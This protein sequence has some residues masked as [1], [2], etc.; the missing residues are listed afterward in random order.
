MK[1]FFLIAA[2]AV[3]T[4]TA[5]AQR[6][7][8]SSSS[9]F[10]TEKATQP[11]TFGA[12]AGVN[13][14]SLGGDT[15]ELDGR[16]AFNVGVSVD[17]PILESFYVQSGLYYTQKGAKREES[18]YDEYEKTT[19]SPSYLEIP[20]LASYRYNFSENSQL[21]FNVGPYLAYGVGGKVK[22]ES[23]NERNE[24]VQKADYFGNLAKR[25]DL[26]WQVGL[27]YT[28][29]HIYAGFAYESSLTDISDIDGVTLRN[30]NFMI[31]LGYN[32]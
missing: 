12:R 14:A 13:F 31:Q 18:D 5:S 27:G 10:S 28:Y 29:K 16:T 19:I 2:C 6:A 21:Q 11:I 9:F 25:F 17:I 20:I 3:C 22:E 30:N 4:L 7:S 26:G 24:R 15:E 23:G 1:K 8:S 32:F